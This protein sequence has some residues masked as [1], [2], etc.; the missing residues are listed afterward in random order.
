MEVQHFSHP[1]HPLVF[2]GNEKTGHPC[3]GCREPVFGPSY[4][5][6]ESRCKELK[7][8]HHQSC[9]EL[10]L[11]LYHPLHPAHPL[12]LFDE[13]TC[14][15][16][17][18]NSKCEVCKEFCWEYSYC[19]YSCDFNIHI[20]CAILQLEA[21]FHDHPLTPI[22]KSIMF[23]C[24][25]CGKEDKGVP[26][27]CSL[28][29]CGFWIHNR[30]AYFPCKVKVVRHKHLLDLTYSSLK[31]HQFDSRFC[32]LCV[33][34]V[35]THYGRYYCSKCDFVAHLDCAMDFRNREDINLLEFKDEEELNEFVDLASFKV[36]KSI[37]GEDGT[38]QAI[39]I[40]HFSHEHDLQLTYKVLNDE[41]CDGCVQAILLPPFYRCVECHFFLHESCAKLPKTKKHPL[42]RHSLTLDSMKPSEYFICDACHC[43][44]N[45]FTYWCETCRYF[46]LDVQCSLVSDILTHPGHKHRLLLSSGNDLPQNCNCC[47]SRPYSIFRCTTCEFAVDFK[48]VALPH[49]T[50][51]E[52]HEHNFILSYTPEDDSDEY[53][54]DICE[55]ERNPKHWFY[56]CADCNYPAHPKCILGKYPNW[57]FGGAYTFDCHP[58]P[59]IFIEKTKDHPLCNKCNESCEELIYQCAQCNFYM[60]NICLLK[61]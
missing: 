55:E 40:I 8:Y 58:H 46:A 16:E 45:G 12:I 52:Q 3:Y 56:Y 30:C 47:D 4:S 60:H 20:K 50:R 43:R 61:R 7:F 33:K 1:D 25:L 26:N 37:V 2:N 23:T 19:C 41:K 21:K 48:C 38:Q 9:A 53:Y 5:C 18:E 42:H 59:L 29:S 15:L 28:I 57:K 32:Q 14:Y 11:G 34:K 49:S 10:P 6:I 44:C 35:E 17:K 36:K 27:L 39:E 22:C 51:Y 31:H 13:T 24:N 54:C